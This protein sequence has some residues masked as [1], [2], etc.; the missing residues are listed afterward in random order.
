[1]LTTKKQLTAREEWMAL[2]NQWLEA[3]IKARDLREKAD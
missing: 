1:M 3:H 2:E